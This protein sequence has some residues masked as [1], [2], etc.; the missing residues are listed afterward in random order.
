MLASVVGVDYTEKYPDKVFYINSLLILNTLEFLKKS[1]CKRVLFSSTSE[2]YAG[3]IDTFNYHVPT[4]EDVPLCI[5]NLHNPRNTYAATKIFGEIGFLNYA[6]VYGFE[7]LIVRYHNVYGPRMGFKHVIPQIVQRFLNNENPFII[8]GHTQTRSFNFIDDAVQGTVLAM[9]KG[10]N[11]NIYH[12]GSREEITIRNLVES[13][14][15]LLNFKGSYIDGPIHLGSVNRR[16]PEI[17]KSEIE[18]GYIPNTYLAEG[19][20][21]TVNWYKHFILSGKKH[22]EM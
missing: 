6:R 16:C 12:I 3:T 4:D 13:V 14:G 22:N 18:L 7:I 17:K 8:Y 19:L 15:E 9:E 21:K 20:K 11:L 5:N 2:C 1:K 10:I